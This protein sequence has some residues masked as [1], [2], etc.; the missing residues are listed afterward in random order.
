MTASYVGVQ[1]TTTFSQPLGNM[2]KGEVSIEFGAGR[3]TVDGLPASSDNFVGGAAGV[4]AVNDLQRSGNT[5]IIR[6]KAPAEWWNPG[7]Y[8]ADWNI[9]LTPRV[10]IDLSL[11]TGAN[12]TNLDLTNL[13]IGKLTLETGASRNVIK[14]PATAGGTDVLI[15]AGAADIQVIVPA[16]VSA[17]VRV[18]GGLVS[19]NVDAS[20]FPKS[21]EYYTSLDYATA[22]NR[23]DLDIRA[24]AASV[25][26]K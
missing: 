16:G 13:K 17:R 24:G 6:I 26:V 8:S 2:Q 18:E 1:Q 15:K 19:T 10:P 12:E 21:G 11:K 7:Y 3:L 5:G 23:I 9:H 22:A 4:G 20:R 14:L 25:T